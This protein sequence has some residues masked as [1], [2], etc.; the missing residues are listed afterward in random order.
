MRNLPDRVFSAAQSPSTARRASATSARGRSDDASTNSCGACAPP[1]RGPRPSTVSG[2]VGGEVARVARPAAAARRR[3]GG[4]APRSAP[5]AAAAPVAVARVHPRPLAH[6]RRVQARAADLVRHRR[7]GRASKASRRVG[8]H[9]A[10]ELAAVGHDVERVARADDGRHDGEARRARAGSWR[11]ATAWAAPARA[12]SALMPSCGRRARVRGAAVRVHLERCPAAL[13]LHDDRSSPSSARWPAS[14]HRQASKPA[15]RVDVVERARPATPRRR[16]AAAPPR[17]RSARARRARAG[18]RGR[19]R[20]RPSCRPCPSRPGGRPRARAAGGRR[21]RR[22]CR[23]GRAAGGAWRPCRVRRTSR[24]GAW[25]GDEHGTRSTSPRP[26]PA[27]RRPRRPPRR[28]GRRRSATRP[29]TSASSSRAARAAMAAACSCDPRIHG[30][31]T[32]SRHGLR[33][34]GR[35]RRPRL[36]ARGHR[37]ILPALRSPGQARRAALLPGRRHRRSARSS[38][39]PIATAPTTWV[40][41]TR[42]SSASPTRTSTRTSAFTEHHGLTVPLLADVDHEVGARLRR[43]GARNRHAPRRLRRRRGRH[44]PLPRGAPPGARLPGRRRPRR[45]VGRAA[46]RARDRGA[47]ARRRRPDGRGDRGAALVAWLGEARTSLDIALYDVRLPGAGR[48]RGGRRDPRRRRG[49]GVAVRIAF[50]A[51]RR[52]RRRSRC[53]RR[54]APSRRC[55]RRSACRCG[56]SPAT[57]TSCTTSTWCATAT[58]CG[59]ARR[60]GRSTRGRAR[61]TSSSP[62]P[63]HGLARAYARDFDDLWTRGRGRGHGQLRR[64]ADRRRRRRGAAVVLARPRARALAPDRQAH[65]RRAERRVRIASPV[66]TAAP[67][68]AA[69]NRGA[70][71]GRRSTSPASSTRTQVAQVFGQWRGERAARRGRRRCSRAC[72]RGLPW[73]RASVSTPYAPGTVHDYM[74]AKVTVADDVVFVGSFNLSRSGEENAENVLEIAR[75]RAGRAAWRRSSTQCAAATRRSRCRRQAAS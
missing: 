62:W 42:S 1:P 59:P 50:N 70:G 29:P 40:R 61:R 6:E 9:V 46:R 64:G 20:R 35:R 75:R 41:S 23:G 56:R 3:S 25:S 4:R 55:S 15:K 27:P 53:R 24:S 38:S 32:L 22:R 57:P 65:R 54:R 19:G 73:S 18:R 30:S 17:R 31:R 63:R 72:S 69:L 37:R 74:H 33:T 58:R 68:L 52:P 39:A 51:G 16:R 34:S 44:R 45:G 71:R 11:A 26:A 43:V 67:I 10:D 13:R 8:A 36:R 28:R 7:R 66:L 21:G 14:K 60:T 5:L 2:I 49:R 47:D 12:S 48:R